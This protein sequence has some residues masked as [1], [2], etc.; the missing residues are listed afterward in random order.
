MFLPFE[1]CQTIYRLSRVTT[2][3]RIS[4]RQFYIAEGR[5][6]FPIVSNLAIQV[7]FLNA[8]LS[9]HTQHMSVDINICSSYSD[10]ITIK[11]LSSTVQIL[12]RSNAYQ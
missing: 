7:K 2:E 3:H 11:H 5:K 10:I 6:I 12:E 1:V 8:E 9:E 4:D